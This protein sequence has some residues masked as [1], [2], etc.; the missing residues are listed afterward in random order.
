MFSKEPLPNIW[1][2][3]GHGLVLH[4]RFSEAMTSLSS[5]NKITTESNQEDLPL[6]L[7]L[8]SLVSGRNL[9]LKRNGMEKTLTVMPTFNSGCFCSAPS[10]TS[11]TSRLEISCTAMITPS[12][13]SL[14]IMEM[15]QMASTA[16]SMSGPGVDG[17]KYHFGTR[18]DGGL[19]MSFNSVS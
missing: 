1:L 10:I 14:S 3:Y 18:P 5:I 16:T 2:P 12:L 17:S 8:A 7:Q 19:D 15:N 11:K 9:T 4:K 6:K 13:I